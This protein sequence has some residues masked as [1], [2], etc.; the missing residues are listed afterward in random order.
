M[1]DLTG[2]AGRRRPVVVQHSFGA[3]GTG[4]PIGA[5]TRVLHSSLAQKYEF[6]QM[7]QDR[8]TGGIDWSRLRRWRD[9]LRE[10]QPDLVHVRGLGNEGL[11]GALA[12]RAA[13][14]P[15][16][17]VSVHGSVR[18]LTA[19]PWL[20]NRVLRQIAEPLTMR[21]AT[22]V[23]TVCEFAARR[24]FIQ[25]HRGK[26]VDPITNGVDLAYPTRERRARSRAALGLS[27]SADVLISVGRTNQREGARGPRC[28]NGPGFAAYRDGSARGR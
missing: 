14:C 6:V 12:A 17:L 25:A 8:A 20:Q 2:T 19:A 15:N 27:A 18:D 10:L 4:G 22:H 21:L 7:H 11:H 1:A 3:L 26:L 24:P 28:G 16:I 13:G 5:L 9:M 23:T